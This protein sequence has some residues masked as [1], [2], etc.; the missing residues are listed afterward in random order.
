MRL[1][2]FDYTKDVVTHRNILILQEGESYYLGYDIS[3]LD[4]DE[5]NTLKSLIKNHLSELAE[6][7]AFKQDPEG[8]TNL[9]PSF[10]AETLTESVSKQ[11]KAIQEKQK[12]EMKRFSKVIRRFNKEHVENTH[13]HFWK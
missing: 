8:I 9:Y 10:P 4:S 5:I 7:D 11:I 1:L 2:E 3:K 12:A 13:T 6:F